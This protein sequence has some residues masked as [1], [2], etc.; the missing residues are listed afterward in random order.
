LQKQQRVAAPSGKA[1]QASG[2][3]AIAKSPD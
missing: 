3:A 1:A 2:I